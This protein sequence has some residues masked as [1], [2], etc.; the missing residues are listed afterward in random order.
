MIRTIEFHVPGKP[1]A[2]ARAGARAGIARDGHAF[3]RHFTKTSQR[4]YTALLRDAAVL[5]MGGGDRRLQPLLGP[6]EL[7]LFAYFG[8]PKCHF[9][10]KGALVPSAPTSYTSKPDVD[11]LAK[12]VGDSLNG[13]LWHD[14]SQIVRL[15]VLKLWG[16]PGLRV[17]VSEVMAVPRQP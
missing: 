4:P 16:D 1:V 11:N 14:D 17:V 10:R 5:A 6:L 15:N 2:W 9:N 3:V 12:I 8:R 13:V 7:N